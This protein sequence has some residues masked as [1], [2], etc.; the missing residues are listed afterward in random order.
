M[1]WPGL[2]ES[3]ESPSR[4]QIEAYS[5]LRIPSGASDL[6]ARLNQVI[7]KRTLFVRFLL[8]PSGVE[9]FLLDSPFR[10]PLSAAAVPDQ[11]KDAF[12]PAWFVPEAARTF[13]AGATARA[14][15]L[16][17]MSEPAKWVVYVTARS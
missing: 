3:T 14:A 16:I 13:V 5:G 7:T 11:L 2:G 8:D 4:G 1:S 10:E 15:I 6:R 12:R 9:S 17:D